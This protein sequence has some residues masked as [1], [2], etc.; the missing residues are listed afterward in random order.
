M[1]QN[2]YLLSIITP[3]YNR[4]RQLRNLYDSLANQNNHKFNW[5]IIDDGST[6]DTNEVVSSFKNSFFEIKFYSQT[7]LGK[8]K[9][10]NNVLQLVNSELVFIVDSD[11]I[12]TPDAVDTIYLDWTNNKDEELIGLSY[13]RKDTRGFII[14]DKFTSI[15]VISTH[16]SERIINDVKGDKAEVWKTSEFKRI[17]FLEFDNERFFSE[18]HKYLALSG[19]GKILFVNKAIYICEYL[20]DGLSSKIRQLQYENPSGTLAN[21]VSLSQRLFPIKIRLKALLKIYAYGHI[22]G[23]RFL[24]VFRDS[25]Y[26]LHWLLLTPL[27]LMYE[28]Y[29]RIHYN[30]HKFLVKS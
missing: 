22:S 10:L 8:H 18:Q 6:D 19:P 13:L 14:G 11:D 16:A 17:P 12:L 5:Y 9:A 30:L 28:Y 27:G 21:A 1:K 7:N 2:S 15:K 4:S 24:T 3:T 29:L 20:E 26:G 25:D 23:I